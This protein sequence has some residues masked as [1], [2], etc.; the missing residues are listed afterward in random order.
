MAGKSTPGKMSLEKFLPLDGASLE[1]RSFPSREKKEE[2]RELTLLRGERK[3]KGR[4]RTNHEGEE[5]RT[6]PSTRQA[7]HGYLRRCFR[8]LLPAS[9]DRGENELKLG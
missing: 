6:E 1:R 3:K 2:Q 8:G 5:R 7:V 9:R 4:P